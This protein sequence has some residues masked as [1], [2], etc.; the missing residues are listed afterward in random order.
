MSSLTKTNKQKKQQ[1][2]NPKQNKAAKKTPREQNTAK[3]FS[4]R[5]VLFRKQQKKMKTGQKKSSSSLF[6]AAVSLRGATAYFQQS[7][8]K[9]RKK[10]KRT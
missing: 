3:T 4:W 1:N 2:P 7:Q 9:I 8:N 6:C 10:G 5:D